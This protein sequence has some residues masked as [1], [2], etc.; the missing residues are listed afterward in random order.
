MTTNALKLPNHQRWPVAEI[1]LLGVAIV[2][3][4]SYGITKQALTYTPI[5]V[6]LAL[7]FSITFIC[8]L[9]K[10]V[11]ELKTM[12]FR[13]WAPAISLGALLFAI[14]CAETFGIFHTSAAKAAVLI[15]TCVLMTPLI[16]WWALKKTPSKMLTMAGL[17]CLIGIGLLTLQNT[18]AIQ[19]NQGDALILLAA[20]L[21]AV[22]VVRTQ[23]FMT[24]GSLSA[25]SITAIQAGVVAIGAIAGAA[26]CGQVNE[27][28]IAR[29]WEFWLLIAY[30]I[31]FCTLF[32]FFAQN[33]GIRRLSATK[34]S[35]LMGTEPLFG[36]VFAVFW[37]GESLNNMQ[38]LGGALI[39]LAT[40]LVL[41][42]P[43]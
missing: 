28:F 4:T 40:T 10:L 13:A 7:R 43:R 1:M 8:L 25:L 12:P 17:L 31:L 24:K 15:S 29:V 6:F 42:T 26:I 21:R 30:L 18:E 9:P 16:E 38:W 37:L 34:A 5:F 11:T 39:V 2:W 22:I 36:A 3:G 20:F 41:R 23:I 14:F 27:L 19:F 35:L 32:A 33:V